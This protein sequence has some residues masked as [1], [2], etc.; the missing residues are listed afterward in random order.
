MALTNQTTLG[1]VR[2]RGARSDP[3]LTRLRL[4]H[5]LSSCSLQPPAMPPSAILFVREMDD[6]LPGC[7]ARDFGPAPLASAEWE[8]AAQHRLGAFYSTAARAL[9]APPPFNADAVVF[10]DY[11]ELLAC[12]ARDL[13]SGAVLGWWWRSIL[14]RIPTRL[15]G[16]WV[17]FWSEHPRYIPAA[18]NHL[19]RQRQALRVLERIAPVQAR[20][21]LT[22]VLRAFDLPDL[23]PAR[24]HSPESPIPPC[25]APVESVNEERANHIAATNT[26]PEQ[27]TETVRS[28]VPP[29]WT[30]WIPPNSI[31]AELGYERQA[32]LGLGLLIHR[33]PRVLS[34]ASFRAHYRAWGAVWQPAAAPAPFEIEK[35]LPSRARPPRDS[36]YGSKTTPVEFTEATEQLSPRS[37]QTL[38]ASPAYVPTSSHKQ[39]LP[40]ANAKGRALA[41][42]PATTPR[43]SAE[44]EIEI[45]PPPVAHEWEA[46]EVTHAGG[47]LYLIHF[48]REAQVMKHFNSNLSGWA[49]L[50]L[51]AR[52]LLDGALDTENDAIWD[53]LA[54]L[55]GRAQKTPPG[56]DFSPEQTYSA[57]VSWL[58]AVTSET[59][60]ARFRGRGVEIWTEEGFLILDSANLEYPS[61]SFQR[62]RPSRFRH[63][64]RVKPLGLCP[65]RELR[66]FLHFVL[67]YATWR[68]DGALRGSAIQDALLRSGRL[69]V[70]DTHVDLVMSMK[71][72]SLAVR[73]AGLDANPGWRPELGRV[74]NFHFV[75]EGY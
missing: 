40:P 47:I 35:V 53:A 46:G 45:S 18:L 49:L 67:P 23:A 42:M 14:N 69:Y 30:P 15:P 32:L 66:R 54:K 59:R 27:T 74:I 43:P 38:H 58:S 20:N 6:P 17:A 26:A 70:T 36:S 44:H 50:E 28:K 10:A 57:P 68:L 62:F 72:I 12:L 55:D 5:L 64:A 31:P 19:E 63:L 75:H 24:V 34:S 52:C 73:K 1:R 33:A 16:S 11:S 21:L 25:A 41:E 65:S 39:E 56:A 48:L 71:E 7:I 2:L 60:F 51:L 9:W 8:R 22:A 29:P 3:M 4:S 37:R 13:A 61:G